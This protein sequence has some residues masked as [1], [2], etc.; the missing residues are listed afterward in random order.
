MADIIPN[1]IV[2]AQN[3]GNMPPAGSTQ[4]SNGVYT[5]TS[6][7]TW[8]PTSTGIGTSS[9]KTTY[10][11][12]PAVKTTDVTT[13]PTTTEK[14]TYNLQTGEGLNTQPSDYTKVNTSLTA[15]EGY[16]IKYDANDNAVVAPKTAQDKL[17]E[18]NDAL[19]N[20]QTEFSTTVNNIQ[21]E[22]IPLSAGEQAQVNSL[23]QQYDDLIAKTIL[24]NT[25][26]ANIAKIA[27]YRTGAAESHESQLNIVNTI[28]SKG[29]QN[30]INLQTQEAGELNKL[31][32]AIKDNNI[33]KIKETYDSYVA[34][35]KETSAE[36][37]KT[38][39]N[40]QKA[41]K[42]AND[43]AEQKVK[44]TLDAL[45]HSDDVTYK[46]KM[47]AI[48]EA[49]LAEEERHNKVTEALTSG[50]GASDIGAN[51]PTVNLIPTGTPNST[52]Q[53]KFLSDLGNTDLASLVKGIAEYRYSPQTYPTRQFKG[54]SGFTQQQVL[55]LVDK[56][57]NGTYQEQN[58]A[59]A[60]KYLSSLQ[61]GEIYRGIQ[62]ANKAINH[63]VSFTNDVSDL[64]NYSTGGTIGDLLNAGKNELNQTFN[65]K[66]QQTIK[67]AQTEANGLKDELAKFFK[68]TGVSDVQ[69]IEN[70]GKQL[71]TSVSPNEL[72]G[73][74]QGALT[75]LSGQLQVAEQSYRNTLNKEPGNTFLQSDTINKLSALKNEG[76]TVDIPGVN[77][78]DIN[79]YKT[80]GGGTDQKLLDAH[81]ALVKANDPNN[82]PTPENALELAQIMQ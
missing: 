27:G 8:N 23:K 57:T 60:Q 45:I 1:D 72:K 71:S 40:T 79:A 34:A 80:Y 44:D 2:T 5:D 11:K 17:T 19:N 39:T 9:Y 28:I 13:S 35:N 10:T 61:S 55:A 53:Q 63:L 20:A 49:K 38:I 12:T 29:K 82:P 54:A 31:T 25:S 50:A 59:S 74:V 6:G 46:N 15:P 65:T 14:P 64:G 56:Y 69:S 66:T 73:V 52:E 36:L 33:T 62:S 32:Q 43:A 81:T 67:S 42:D 7:N 22:T 4:G 77:Y 37:Q 58:Y 75:L 26:A 51:L 3:N 48:D 47:A 21:N 16:T 41:I 68:G 30:V 18:T 70:W 24:Q 78:T 76:Y